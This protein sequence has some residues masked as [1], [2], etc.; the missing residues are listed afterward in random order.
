MLPRAFRLLAKKDFEKVFRSGRRY[1]SS[2]LRAFLRE[3]AFGRNRLGF[4]VAAK[5]A[6]K[7]T[8]RNREKRRLRA[9]TRKLLPHLLQGFDVII[10]LRRSPP[11]PLMLEKDLIILF[12]KARLYY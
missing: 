12:R 5:V 6:P 1:E 8:V 3:N 10:S 11:S 9:S 7:A 4:L 2:F